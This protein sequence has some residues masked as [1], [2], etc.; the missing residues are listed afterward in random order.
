MSSSWN[1][2]TGM[3]LDYVNNDDGGF[4]QVNVTNNPDVW[5]EVV[6]TPE[7]SSLVSLVSGLTALGLII[8][9]WKT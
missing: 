9:R 5:T 7:P 3:G 4:G 2:D 8:F 1:A 6:S